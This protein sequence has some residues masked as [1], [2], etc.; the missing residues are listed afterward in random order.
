MIS[1]EPH[2]GGCPPISPQ[3]GALL[4]PHHSRDSEAQGAPLPLLAQ[5]AGGGQAAASCP[6]FPSGLTSRRT[7]L[8]AMTTEVT[9]MGPDFRG[10][11]KLLREVRALIPYH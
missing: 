10:G 9:Q 11:P 7:T 8:T 4:T 5:R 3:R 2:L 6:A 1:C